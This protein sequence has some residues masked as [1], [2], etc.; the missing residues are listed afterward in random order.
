[1]ASTI[2]VNTHEAKAHFIAS[3]GTSCGTRGIV[4]T[5]AGNPKVRILP[6]SKPRCRQPGLGTGEVTDAF[7][8]RLS[9]DELAGWEQ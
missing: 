9:E 2:T 8:E 7:F 3:V 6:I 4:I 5:K 1:V